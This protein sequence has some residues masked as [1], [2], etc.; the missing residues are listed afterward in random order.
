MDRTIASH[1]KKSAIRPRPALTAGI[2]LGFLLLVLVAV[3]GVVAKYQARFHEFEGV[4][5]PSGRAVIAQAGATRW[6]TYEGGSRSRLAVLLTDPN[7]SWLGLVHALKA[8][9][10]PF[11]ITQDAARAVKHDVVLVYPRLSG[12]VLSRKAL[13]ALAAFPRRGGHLIGVNVLGGGLETVFGFEQIAPSRT[14]STVE[15]IPG[16]SPLLSVFSEPEER[17]IPLGQAPKG[18]NGIGTI[19]YLGAR[20]TALA[21]FDDGA[22]AIVWRPIGKGSAYAIGFDIGDY[23]FRAQHRRHHDANRSYVNGFEP[24]ADVIARLVRRIYRAVTPTAATLGTVPQGKRVAVIFTYDVDYSESWENSLTYAEFL[25]SQ[26]IRGTFFLQTKYIGDYNDTAFFDDAAVQVMKHLRALGM[27]V[28]SHSVSHARAFRWM[29]LGSGDENYP[30]YQPEVKTRRQVVGGSVFGEMRVSKFMIEELG[31][32]DVV[33]FRPGYLS[34]PDALPQA[35]DATGYR[36]S[37]SMTANSA[38]SHLPFRL[39]RNRVA[40]QETGIYEFP[41][42]IEDEK[43][44]PMGERTEDAI[45]LTEKLGRYGGTVVVLTH[46]NVLGHKF[47]FHKKFIA[48]VRDQAWF[49]SLSD[50]GQWWAARDAAEMDVKCGP[51]RCTIR[52]T[53]PDPVAGL[54]VQ[55]PEGCVLDRKSHKVARPTPFGAVI[56]M[57][58]GELTLRCR[59]GRKAAG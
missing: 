21:H 44:P 35:L 31:G 55:L 23:F 24:A 57:A 30:A 37:S 28:G 5:G 42:T 45:Q 34:Y 59:R 52:I 29:P 25:K 6:Q 12:R 39:N 41:V 46:P 2:I 36:Y 19:G 15:L 51:K 11:T 20:I 9:G 22:P 17:V 10:I 16:A 18:Q 4:A 40:G 3:A 47:E 48:A 26:G 43:L 50:Y 33:S 54:P 8:F 38:L 56:E 14:R 53:A 27:E 49:G 13:R 1:D 58:Q 7:S 32:G